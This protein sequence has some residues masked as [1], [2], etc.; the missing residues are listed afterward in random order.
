MK[1]KNNIKNFRIIKCMTRKELSD[2]TGITERQLANIEGGSNITLINAYKIKIALQV[3]NLE[4][5]FY[6]SKD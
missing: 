1:V 3:N 2:K 6:I 4:E 5:L